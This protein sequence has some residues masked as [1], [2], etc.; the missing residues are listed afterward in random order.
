MYLDHEKLSFGFQHQP[1]DEFFDADL[2]AGCA[3]S[4]EIVH[5]R[6]YVLEGEQ[7]S[8]V[9]CVGL[10][11]EILDPHVGNV[12]HSGRDR[13]ADPLLHVFRRVADSLTHLGNAQVGDRNVV[14]VEIFADLYDI[15]A[16]FFAG[17]ADA[18]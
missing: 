15:R 7:G 4:P 12:G 16:S 9:E 17:H 6:F 5:L 1:V 10:V 14:V 11:H 18:V 13:P 8:G 2:A 3:F